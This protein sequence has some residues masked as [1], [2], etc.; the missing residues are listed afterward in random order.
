MTFKNSDLSLLNHANGFTLWHYRTDSALNKTMRDDG[1][2]NHVIGVMNAG[3]IIIINAADTTSF[4]RV[5]SVVGDIRVE[6]M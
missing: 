6:K 2:F 5:A 4:V 3:D 1:Y